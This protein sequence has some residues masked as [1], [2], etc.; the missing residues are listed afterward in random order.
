MSA[1]TL[2]FIEVAEPV[3]NYA[4]NEIVPTIEGRWSF[5]REF[6]ELFESEK[7]MI[8]RLV[9]QHGTTNQI[10][11]KLQE[12]FTKA[13]IAN[14]KNYLE[15]LLREQKQYSERLSSLSSFIFIPFVVGFMVYA[16][17]RGTILLLALL[18]VIPAFLFLTYRR[19]K[20]NNWTR[21]LK[22]ACE[23]IEINEN[24]RPN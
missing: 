5:L 24:Y 2:N 13:E 16:D 20:V 17:Q 6:I 14:Y 1:N 12:K 11:A 10:A 15:I 8:D 23:F 4:K 18:S 9:K 21:E 3:H 7:K 19:R 22:L